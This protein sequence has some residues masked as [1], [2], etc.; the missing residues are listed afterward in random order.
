MDP[1]ARF[2]KANSP[3]TAACGF[4]VLP[5][6]ALLIVQARA[7]TNEKAAASAD[8]AKPAHAQTAALW[9]LQPIQRVVPPVPKA[10]ARVK[11][12]IDAFV[13]ARL[14]Q[15]QLAPAAPAGRVTLL[16][17][18]CFDLTGLPPTPEQIESFMKDTRPDAYAALIERLLASPQYG[19]RWGRH[20]LDVVRYADTGGFENDLR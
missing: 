18:A 14:E 4:I 13:L 19:E 2:P 7:A 12:P 10:K 20:W 1:D 9:S 3:R 8:N 6:A 5:L 16:R 17:R 11:N 15:N